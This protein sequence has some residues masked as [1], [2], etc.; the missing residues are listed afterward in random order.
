LS[1]PKRKEGAKEQRGNNKEG[2]K[3][4]RKEGTKEGR[5]LR[6]GEGKK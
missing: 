1:P 5:T 4:R 2:K 6:E 3:D